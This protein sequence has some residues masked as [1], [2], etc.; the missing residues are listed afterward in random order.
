MNQYQNNQNYNQPNI[1]IQNM[2]GNPPNDFNNALLFN[3][4]QINRNLVDINVHTSSLYS[5]LERLNSKFN[6]IIIW[7]ILPGILVVG[8]I[9]FILFFSG[10]LL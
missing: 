10:M 9:I 8:A 6:F 4:N 3:L 1:P 7:L 2:Q 5:Q